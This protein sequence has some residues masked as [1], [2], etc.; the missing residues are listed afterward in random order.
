MLR[1][2]PEVLIQHNEMF[3][4]MCVLLTLRLQLAHTK[5]MDISLTFS[6]TL[7]WRTAG[8]EED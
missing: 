4:I 5:P 8:L 3:V 2:E 1:F 6:L 7:N